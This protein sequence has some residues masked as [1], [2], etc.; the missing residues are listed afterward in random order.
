MSVKLFEPFT[1]RNIELANRAVV[2]PMCQYSAVHGQAQP[3]HL[4]HYG[5]LAV[6]GP[7]LVVIEATGV[8]PEGRISD[9]CLG[10]WDDATEAALANLVKTIKSFGLSRIGIQLNHA[11]RK[12]GGRK[13]WLGAGPISPQ[14]RI[15]APSA[16]PI[17]SAALMPAGLDEAEMARI[18]D[19]F[20][21]AVLRADRVGIDVIELHSA[22]GYL[23]HQFLSPLS[24]QRRDAYGGSLENRCRFPLEV[25][26]SA[27]AAL[28]AHRPLGIRIS[29]TDWT[30]GGFTID[31]AVVYAKALKDAGLDFIC[32]SSGGNTPNAQIPVAPGYQVELSRRIRREAGIATRAVGLIVTPR[33]AEDVLL[34]GDADL[35]ALARGML[36]NPRWVWHAAQILGAETAYP[37]QYIRASAKLWPGAR[38]ARG[39]A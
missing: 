12:G 20:V 13:P 15:V 4:Q 37:P 7:G 38:L 16:I 29:A 34:A 22:H 27:R 33:Q 2:A 26:A 28:P 6:S 1:L 14:W 21:A 36:D 24:N 10:L 35:I 18:K 9:G 39:G 23:L 30:D 3:W 11:G 19:A 32:V 31:E 5:S 8:L 25:V 17:D